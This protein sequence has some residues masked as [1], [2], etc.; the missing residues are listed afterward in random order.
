[1]FETHN[2]AIWTNSN[3]KISQ[4]DLFETHNTATFWPIQMVKLANM[5]CLKHNTAIWTNS[6]S[7]ISQHDMFETHNT[8]IWTNSNG[9][10]LSSLGLI[11]EAILPNL[12]FLFCHQNLSVLGATLNWWT[13]TESQTPKIFSSIRASKT[14]KLFG[15]SKMPPQPKRC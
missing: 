4:Y 13:G 7:K 12:T 3:G 8:A 9:K 10:I 14:I 11:Q 2:T 1:M 5:T 6:N 15:R